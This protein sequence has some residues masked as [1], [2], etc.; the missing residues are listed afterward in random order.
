MGTAR[1]YDVESRRGFSVI[2]FEACLSDCKWGDIERVGAELKALLT[3]ASQPFCLLDLSKLEFMGSS[4]VALL[5]RVWKTVQ[6]RQGGMVVVNPNT[7][8]KEVLE[9]AGLSKVWTI[10][11][12]RPEGEQALS[13]VLPVDNSANGVLAAIIGWTIAGATVA[14]F[15]LQRNGAVKLEPQIIQAIG[16]GGG[17][18]AF[19]LNV[20]AIVKG[21]GAWRFFGVLGVVIAAV[22]I[23]AAACN[24][25]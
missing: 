18:L 2:T 25:L 24:L 13:K 4:I 11:N 20:L 10:C 21:K 22:L 8:T 3:G 7:M 14:S 23:A 16:Y 5:V 15:L 12:S 17:G 6:E 1:E 9:I 19:V